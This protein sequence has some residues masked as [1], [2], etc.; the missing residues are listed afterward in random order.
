LT[1]KEQVAQ[2]EKR[3]AAR[4]NLAVSI[5]NDVAALAARLKKFEAESLSLYGLL[6]DPDCLYGDSP[7]SHLNTYRW[8]KEWMIKSDMDFIGIAFDG[9]VALRPFSENVIEGHGWVMR[10]AKKKEKPKT[11]IDAITK[12]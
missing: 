3:L 8:L 12:G 7:L 1:D 2:I 6:N 11:G 5:Q 4:E 10:W 9:K